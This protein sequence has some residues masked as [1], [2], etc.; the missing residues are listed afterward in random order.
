MGVVRFKTDPPLNSRARQVL[1][2]SKEKFQETFG[3]YYVAGYQLGGDAG[4]CLTIAHFD[5]S[6]EEQ[7]RITATIKVLWVKKSVTTATT[8]KTQ[9]SQDFISF[10]GYDTL[11][12]RNDNIHGNELWRIQQVS[13]DCME[14]I[15][16]L[17]AAVTKKLLDLGCDLDGETSFNT[18]TNLCDAGVVV[19][20]ILVPY[21]RLAEY[22][23]LT[24]SWNP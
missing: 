19:Q 4:A 11:Q 1:K 6:Q 21:A 14:R 9:L 2:F 13:S 18:C 5:Q 3:D 7:S 16:N 10:C 17:Q 24:S 12:Q 22:M 15:D 20:L 23:V 8:T